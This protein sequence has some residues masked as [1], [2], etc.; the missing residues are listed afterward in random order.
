MQNCAVLKW[1]KL[2]NPIFQSVRAVSYI[3][4][5]HASGLSWREGRRFSSWAQQA[6]ARCSILAWPGPTRKRGRGSSRV[7]RARVQDRQARQEGGA[8]AKDPGEGRAERTTSAVSLVRVPQQ[9]Q[10][11]SSHRRRSGTYYYLLI[12]GQAILQVARVTCFSRLPP[13]KLYTTYV[14]YK[15]QQ[16]ERRRKRVWDRVSLAGKTF[17]EGSTSFPSLCNDGDHLRMKPV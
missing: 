1:E 14:L 10:A 6:T 9:P 4:H 3:R 16:A 2:H 7:E 8:E 15:K 5:A 12:C 17:E 11:V 13:T